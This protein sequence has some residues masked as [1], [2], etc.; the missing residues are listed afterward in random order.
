M[1][2]L[3]WASPVGLSYDFK[4]KTGRLDMALGESCDMTACIDL[5]QGIDPKVT[6]IKTYSGTKADT[7]YHRKGRAWFVHLPHELRVGG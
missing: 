3:L 4:T 1:T 2:K 7:S 6:T 5:F